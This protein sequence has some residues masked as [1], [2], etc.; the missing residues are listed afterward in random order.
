MLT[1]LKFFGIA[2]LI[3]IGLFVVIQSSALQ[4]DQKNSR[5]E[6]DKDKDKDKDK[7]NT[8]L[9]E[10]NQKNG[11]ESELIKAGWESNAA[12][13][14]VALNKDWFTIHRVEKQIYLLKNLGHY[15]QLMPLFESHPET[16]SLLAAANNPERLA[17]LFQND[18]C[19][20]IIT[21]LFV[22]HAA[23]EDAAALANAL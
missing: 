9:T 10:N 1:S 4:N 15:S 11:L 14:V 13:A 21:G 3:A 22:Q 20:D 7:D 16:A 2:A 18:D 5:I 23:P 12:H 19:Y 17:Q 8:P 6:L